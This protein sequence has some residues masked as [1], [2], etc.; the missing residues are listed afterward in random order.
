LS[1]FLQRWFQQIEGDVRTRSAS[2]AASTLRITPPNIAN[3][4]AF[5]ATCASKPR[6]HPCENQNQKVL[7]LELSWSR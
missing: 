1:I 4:F 2:G 3:A 7:E 5:S 6:T